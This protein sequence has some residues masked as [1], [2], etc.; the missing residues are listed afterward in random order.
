MVQGH[1]IKKKAEK[2]DR[3]SISVRGLPF[4]TVMGQ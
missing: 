3:V 4:D 2:D 1:F